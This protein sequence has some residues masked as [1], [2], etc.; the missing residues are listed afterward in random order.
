M[1]KHPLLPDGH[2]ILL[3]K[4]TRYF[5]TISST[6]IPLGGDTNCDKIHSNL[7]SK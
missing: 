4:I 2:Q 1:G 6:W 7:L 3:N 5:V